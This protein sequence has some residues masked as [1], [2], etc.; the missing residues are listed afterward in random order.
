MSK[1]IP[2][3][4]SIVLA[5]LFAVGAYAQAK[6]EVD[7]AEGKA[8]VVKKVS[9]EEKAKARAARKAEGASAAK[10]EKPP[11]STGEAQVAKQP[12]VPKISA[13]EKAAARAKRKAAAAQAVKK[14]ETVKGEVSTVK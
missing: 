11:A 6:G 10:S 5:Q 8:P 14:E 1:S 13:E 4:L 3:A 12:V 9:P 7:P 2:I